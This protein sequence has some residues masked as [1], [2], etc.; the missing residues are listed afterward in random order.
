MSKTMILEI[1]SDLKEL[2]KVRK[3]IRD[4]CSKIEKFD[5][6]DN[7]VNMIELGIHELLVNII[8]HAN[9][10]NPDKL[11]RISAR[12]GHEQII[13][14]LFDNG[15]SFNPEI[16]PLPQF[17]GSCENGFGI[18]ITR[19]IFNKVEYLQ[20]KNQENHTILTFTIGDK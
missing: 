15:I 3:Y 19:Q 17:D 18:Y 13:F 16:V 10:G 8:K 12:L 1:K 2:E 5:S 14:E 4:F 11:I 6:D 9:K 20:N 7:R